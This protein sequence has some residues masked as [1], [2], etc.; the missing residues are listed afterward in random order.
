MRERAGRVRHLRPCRGPRG[1]AACVIAASPAGLTICVGAGLP[2]EWQESGWP[3]D[4]GLRSESCTVT[5]RPQCRI[6]WAEEENRRVSPRNAQ[7]T[8]A[9]SG[10][11]PPARTSPGPGHR[12]GC[13]WA[14]ELTTR[15]LR[16]E[17]GLDHCRAAR[18][19][20]HQVV[21][22]RRCLPLVAGVAVAGRVPWAGWAPGTGL[23]AGRP[24]AR[25]AGVG[26]ELD[27]SRIWGGG[28]DG[29]DCRA[30]ER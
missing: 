15:S 22:G 17:A 9:I 4:A 2:A 5:S 12:R 23:P 24:V 10:P 25:S 1:P 13:R 18:V 26:G 8:A 3:G 28:A 7:I 21:Q 27:G 30:L 29:V 20:A 16:C 11:A 6:A 14:I 19:R